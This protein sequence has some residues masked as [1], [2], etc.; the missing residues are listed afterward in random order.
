[1]MRRYRKQEKIDILCKG[2]GNVGQAFNF[3]L[4][5]NYR[6]LC[7]GDLFIQD[8]T[9]IQS[10][11]IIMTRRIGISKSVELDL[12][13]FIKDNKWVSKVRS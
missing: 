10:K 11:E 6:S 13:F 4:Q 2:P 12:R 8:D 3:G 9:A 1:M 7:S 5:D